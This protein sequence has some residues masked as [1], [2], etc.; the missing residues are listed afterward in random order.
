M[1]NTLD[2][3]NTLFKNILDEQNQLIELHLSL[4]DSVYYSLKQTFIWDKEE[5]ISAWY[6]WLVLAARNYNKELWASFSTYATIR[7]KWAM[8]D[9]SRK[10]DTC[11]RWQRVNISIINKYKISYHQIHWKYPTID[12]ISKDTWLSI[13]KIYSSLFSEKSR[14]HTNCEQEIHWV[15]DNYNKSNIQIC[16]HELKEKFWDILSIEEKNI[17]TFYCDNDL[18][19]KDIWA[20]YWLSESRISQKLNQ[21]KDKI[22]KRIHK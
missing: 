5:Y 8:I 22:K 7:I 21:M 4:V 9:E 20:I 1:N 13:K 6:E 12:K 11:T 10:L 16:I 14:I 3:W 15:C 19:L 18:T 17:Y 2:S